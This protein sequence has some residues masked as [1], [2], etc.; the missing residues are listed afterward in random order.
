MLTEKKSIK[1]NI[2]LRIKWLCSQSDVVFD[3]GSLKALSMI[4]D[5][6]PLEQIPN[7][8]P[9]GNRTSC[10]LYMR[11]KSGTFIRAMRV[12][13]GFLLLGFG[14]YVNYLVSLYVLLDSVSAVVMQISMYVIMFELFFVFLF[15]GLSYERVSCY[16]SCVNR[17]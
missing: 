13:Y 4:R 9:N 1:R 11:S 7:V 17:G 10:F 8:E 6:V 14:V 12:H 2:G 16:K 5:G 15:K 3:A